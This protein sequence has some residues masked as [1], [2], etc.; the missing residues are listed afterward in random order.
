M[1]TVLKF[2]VNFHPI[3]V[4]TSIHTIAPDSTAER[5]A[6]SLHLVDSQ[7]NA[8]PISPQSTY[9]GLP[10]PPDAGGGWPGAQG[11]RLAE[12]VTFWHWDPRES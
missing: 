3:L 2:H 12:G 8:C 6:T 9:H 7:A 1:S 10:S 11:T 5:A 4:F